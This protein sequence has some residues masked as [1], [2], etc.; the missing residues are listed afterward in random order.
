MTL[1]SIVCIDCVSISEQHFKE[2]LFKSARWKNLL[3]YQVAWGDFFSILEM[4]QRMHKILRLNCLASVWKGKINYMQLIAVG[5]GTWWQP[6]I[7]HLL[8]K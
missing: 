1:I 5:S 3:K 7:L 4:V 8:I 6:D 2:V